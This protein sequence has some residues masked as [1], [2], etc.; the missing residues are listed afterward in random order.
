MH[1]KG[2]AVTVSDALDRS[3]SVTN[4]LSLFTLQWSLSKNT[5]ARC[6]TH[7]ETFPM[8]SAVYCSLLP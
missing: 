3:L 6:S 5:F 1:E 7:G 8:K 2:Q 4:M